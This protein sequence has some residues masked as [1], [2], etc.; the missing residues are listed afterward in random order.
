MINNTGTFNLQEKL[1]QY[2]SGDQ[3]EREYY[4][5]ITFDGRE[6]NKMNRFN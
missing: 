5:E 1:V 2:S 4:E 3:S 6:T